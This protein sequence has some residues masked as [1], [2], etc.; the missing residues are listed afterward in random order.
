MST[1]SQEKFHQGGN[2][3]VGSSTPG[4]ELKKSIFGWEKISCERVIKQNKNINHRA[5]F[6]LGPQSSFCL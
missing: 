6:V 2:D 1:G 3:G 5:Y 4:R